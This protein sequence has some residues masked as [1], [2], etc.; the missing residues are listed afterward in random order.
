[1]TLLI[2]QII[3][4]CGVV[5]FSITL[6]PQIIKIIKTKQVNDLSSCFLILNL[7]SSFL[8][9]YS[10]IISKNTQFVIVN[11]VSI[12]QTFILLALIAYNFIIDEEIPKLD[13]LTFLDA[14]PINSTNLSAAI[15]FT[16]LF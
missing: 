8:L 14:F 16:P 12:I 13:Y 3:E 15:I 2:N 11:S 5:L 6:S 4:L 7:C 10:A 9:G 1:M